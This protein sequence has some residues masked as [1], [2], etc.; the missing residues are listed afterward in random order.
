MSRDYRP[1][2]ADMRRSCERIVKYADGFSYEQFLA[3]ERTYDAVLRH[4]I[5]IGEAIKQIPEQFREQHSQVEW[6]RIARFRDLVIHHYFA[7]II[8]SF[9]MS[10]RTKFLNCFD[11]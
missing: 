8:K 3:D 6:R 1:Y 5:V 2:L 4:L 7:M 10:C 11:I 9:G